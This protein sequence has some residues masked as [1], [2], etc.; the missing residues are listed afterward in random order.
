MKGP[1]HKN[2]SHILPTSV[3]KNKGITR[4]SLYDLQYQGCPDVS[5]SK[6]ITLNILDSAIRKI[7]TAYQKLPH[8]D[9][10]TKNTKCMCIRKLKKKK[11]KI[12]L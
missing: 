10:S 3:K 9:R 1:T 12:S 4:R 8:C 6:N 5:T 11:I 2:T 7:N